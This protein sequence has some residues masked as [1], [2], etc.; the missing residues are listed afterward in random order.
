MGARLAM[1]LAAA[2]MTTA[3][4]TASAWSLTQGQ[5]DQAIAFG[6]PTLAVAV[7][8]ALMIPASK[9]AAGKTG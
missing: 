5:T 3:G 7:T 2:L 9:T 1:L 4:F 8:L 6:W